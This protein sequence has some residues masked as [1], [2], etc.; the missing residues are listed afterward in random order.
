MIFGFIVNFIHNDVGVY[1][2]EMNM[3]L[4]VLIRKRSRFVGFFAMQSE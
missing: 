2:T 4:V 3:N 1:A